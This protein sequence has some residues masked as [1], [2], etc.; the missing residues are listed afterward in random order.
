MGVGAIFI[1]TLAQTKLPPPV[2]PPT[3]QVELLA[4]SIK[5]IVSFLVLCS[6]IIHGLSIP[7]F[8]LGRRVHTISRTHSIGLVRTNDSRM[9]SIDDRTQRPEPAWLSGMRRVVPGQ[10]IR[11]NRDDDGDDLEKG[12]MDR[13]EDRRMTPSGSGSGGS[14]R[15]GSSTAGNSPGDEKSTGFATA[16]G[17][18]GQKKHSSPP[19]RMEDESLSE[20]ENEAART[21]THETATDEEM[22]S[23]GRKT[24]PLQEY[25]EGNDLIIERAYGE[26][27]DVSVGSFSD[28]PSIRGLTP[29]SLL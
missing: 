2:Y 9:R 19:P 13:E 16:K 1:A 6:V 29:A 5:P 24:P 3:N 25:R 4:G 17:H 18:D 28:H 27:E 8:S 10:E 20:L 23:E 7:F 14:V 21:A 11:I 22:E 15:S 12:P 26:N